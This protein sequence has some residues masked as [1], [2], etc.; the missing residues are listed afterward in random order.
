M[1]E[2]IK[3]IGE[4]E[5]SKAGSEL[6]TLVQDLASN[7]NYSHIMLVTFEV[8]SGV[9]ARYL[10][11]DLEEIDSLR[12]R[13]YLYRRGSSRGTDVTPTSLIAKSL[14]TT[15][16]IKLD[17]WIKKN[18]D[19]S[20]DPFLSSLAAAYH[21]AHD[22]IVSDIKS[23]YK[24]RTN[25]KGYALTLH[26]KDDGT[27]KYPGDYEC[28]RSFIMQE[29]DQPGVVERKNHVCSICG[30]V[31]PVVYGDVIPGKTL[32]FYNWDKPGY[33]A[34]GF[35]RNNMWKNLP[36]CRDCAMDLEAGTTYVDQHLNFA[37]SGARYYLIPKLVVENKAVLERILG[38]FRTHE[39]T[40]TSTSEDG[41][42]KATAQEKLEATRKAER[43]SECFAIKTMGE[44][45]PA[46]SFD[47]LFYDKPQKQTFKI[48]QQIQDVAPGRAALV[49]DAMKAADNLPV[50]KN[51]LPTADGARES[52]EFSFWQ[53]A[54]FFKKPQFSKK[55]D[56]AKD[57]T[58]KQ[59]YLA[60]VADIFT[61]GPVGKDYIL[62]QFI[63][64]LRDE[65]LEGMYHHQGK[66]FSFEEWTLRAFNTLLLLQ[67]CHAIPANY[68]EVKNMSEPVVW[69]QLFNGN[70][71]VNTP[72]KKATFLTGVL[73]QRLLNIQWLKRGS[74]PFFKELKGLRLKEKDIKGLF[75]K[76]I[77]KLEEY[78]KNYRAELAQEA[79]AQFAEAGDN[80]DLTIDEISFIFSLGMTLANRINKKED[81]N[82][83]NEQK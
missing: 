67:G 5:R 16:S 44:Q 12:A 13:Q 73:T 21:Q 83:D 27:R 33:I 74:K 36:V 78:D 60:I 25:K 39:K 19:D 46:V 1:L 40:L 79:A 51:A 56:S 76:I 54:Q 72:A 31:K 29:G 24:E 45:S 80:W 59:E 17:A 7:R 55:L 75:P 35:S 42:K 23:V 70:T 57:Q 63:Q 15:I 18:T 43:D 65:L 10:G 14:E 58:W 64:K 37:L 81:D 52:I 11:T 9:V 41:E 53:L 28:F 34:S 66:T 61:G 68:G 3:H 2:A 69:D 49:M 77:N 4:L 32:T 26:F 48:L 8:R 30:R 22:R 20:I 71:A 38:E 47:L 82:A 50:F 6:D 62:H